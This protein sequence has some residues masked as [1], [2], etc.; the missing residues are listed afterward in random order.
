MTIL[1]R[2]RDSYPTAA[3]TKLCDKKL[4]IINGLG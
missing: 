2:L 1:W 4:R 3:M